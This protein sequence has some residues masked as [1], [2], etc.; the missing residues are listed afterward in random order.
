M[1]AVGGYRDA[2]TW[3]VDVDAIYYAMR[4]AGIETFQ[5]LAARTGMAYMT[6]HTAATGETARPSAD[7]MMRL[8]VALGCEV[9]DL[10]MERE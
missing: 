9:S 6:L 8:S 2:P 5:D 7:T 4:K 1:V 10:M 3:V